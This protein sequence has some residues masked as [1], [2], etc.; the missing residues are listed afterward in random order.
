MLRIL[1][2]ICFLLGV[3]GIY[4]YFEVKIAAP[5][6]ENLEILKLSRNE[7]SSDF[8]TFG[9]SWIKKSEPGHWEMYLEGNAFERG[10]AHGKLARELVQRQ[11]DYFIA[12]IR[13]LIPSEHYLNFI[14]YIVAW[15]NRDIDEFID[16]E[17]QEEIFGVSRAASARYDFIAPAFERM[18]NYHGAHD[19]GHALVN[20]NMVGCTS[21]STWTNNPS[22]SALLIARNFDFY[23]GDDFSREKIVCF[24]NPDEGLQ[25]MT[26]TWGG[27]I[28]AVSGMNEKGVT[29]T[30]NAAASEPPLKGKTPISLVARKILQY[31]GNIE[32]AVEI[33]GRYE[34]Y[35][36][37]TIMIGSAEDNETA[38][39][40]KS[41]EKSSLFKSDENRIICSNHFQSN[42]FENDELNI[43]NI[44]TSDSPYRFER[45]RQLMAKTEN[46]DVA[47]AVSILRNQKGVDEK[48]L[49]MGNQK[50]IN[51]LL[52]HHAVVFKPAEKRVWVSTWP[53]QLGKFMCYHLPTVFSKKAGMVKNENITEH[54]NEIPSDPFLYSEEFKNFN[55]FKKLKMEIRE[56]TTDKEIAFSQADIQTFT[57]L[58]PEYYHTHWLA[59]DFY[60]SQGKCDEAVK[61]YELALAKEIATLSEKE[62]IEENLQRCSSK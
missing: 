50:A 48:N 42:E 22:D 44:A 57:Q 5:E 10:V 40:E 29:V 23:F 61:Y 58:N 54:N 26:V 56:A 38:L 18:L 21:F 2:L 34:T 49:G 7:G 60:R 14:K 39:I 55:K 33:A 16:A 1:V 24:V 25:F 35:V 51:Q 3:F 13:K 8:F 19:I 11:E 52:A 45:V 30:L 41:P 36:S 20:M 12:E 28:G 59:G 53:Y 6:I 62:T 15:M 17:F 43:E 27:F 9:K 32:E 31:A 4:F 46:M 37:E 47:G